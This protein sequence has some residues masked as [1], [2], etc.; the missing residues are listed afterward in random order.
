MKDVQKELAQCEATWRKTL[1]KHTGTDAPVA[2]ADRTLGKKKKDAAADPEKMFAAFVS[3]Q[4]QVDR[5]E[6]RLLFLSFETEMDLWESQEDST[7][8][9]GFCFVLSRLGSPLASF[10]GP[11]SPSV[12]Q[13]AARG[14]EIGP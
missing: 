2:A 12:D 10:L 6:R 13:F 14:T 3:L 4:E 7:K 11:V 5:E 8:E 1:D 9:R